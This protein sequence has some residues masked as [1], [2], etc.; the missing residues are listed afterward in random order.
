MLFIAGR[1]CFTEGTALQ[2]G[3]K[4]YIPSNKEQCSTTDVQCSVCG[5]WFWYRQTVEGICMVCLLLYP[6]FRLNIWFG[7]SKSKKYQKALNTFKGII[8]KLERDDE[9]NPDSFLSLNGQ[10]VLFCRR[11]LR[12]LI[13]IAG[14]WKYFKL[15]I[16]KVWIDNYTALEL[17]RCADRIVTVEAKGE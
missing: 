14:S 17:M 8:R 15:Q 10:E 7:E 13:N 9:Y 1:A 5:D 11:R 16:C 12:N 2:G 3:L 4:K 6:D